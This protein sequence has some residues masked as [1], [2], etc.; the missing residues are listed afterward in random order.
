MSDEFTT[1]A[2]EILFLRQK[3]IELLLEVHDLQIAAKHEPD[4]EYLKP[5]IHTLVEKQKLAVQLI[6]QATVFE[7][8]LMLRQ[9]KSIE[10]LIEKI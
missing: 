9:K 6:Q 2:K 3:A 8:D 7:K 4:L 10:E 1:R 5:M